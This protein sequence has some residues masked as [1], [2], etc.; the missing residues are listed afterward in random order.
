MLHRGQAMGD[1]QRGAPAHQAG[2]CLLDQVFALCIE[3]AGGFVQQQDW[4]VDQQRPG[5]RQALALP[6]GQADAALAQ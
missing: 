2:Q 4:C 3:G 1:H 5:N 6:A